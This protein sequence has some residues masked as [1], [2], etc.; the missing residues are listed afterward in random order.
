M[1]KALEEAAIRPQV[2][3]GTSIGA[4]NGSVIATGPA[5]RESSAWPIS[6]LRSALRPVRGRDWERVKNTATLRAGLH[7]TNG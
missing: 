2:V 4:F 7:E 5:R 3:L 6:G 1:I